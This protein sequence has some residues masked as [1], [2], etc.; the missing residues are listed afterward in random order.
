MVL[1]G[2]HYGGQAP[3]FEKV[4]VLS[5]WNSFPVGSKLLV[6][7]LSYVWE[8]RFIRMFLKYGLST[9]CGRGGSSNGFDSLTPHLVVE[10]RLLFAHIGVRLPS[11]VMSRFE[12]CQHLL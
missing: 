11:Q 6:L 7:W 8:G 12:G 9:A 3:R 10:K 1:A 2:M 4:Y 5:N